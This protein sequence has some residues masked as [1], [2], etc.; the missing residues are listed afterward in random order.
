MSIK[1]QKLD[2]LYRHHHFFLEDDDE[3]YFAGEYTARA[4]FAE[5]STNQ[6]IS[7]LKK[8]I[9]VRGTAQWRYK[10][11]AINSIGNYQNTIFNNVKSTVTFVPVPP[12]RAKSDALYDDRLLQVL[13][14]MAQGDGWD[15]CELVEQINTQDAAHNH[16]DGERPSIESLIENYRLIVP[17]GYE[18]RN[19]IAIYD[20]VL[21]TGRHFK[22]MQYVIK[23]RFPHANIIG[24][25]F[26]RVARPSGIV[27]F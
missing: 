27:E 26:A 9:S 13:N 4:G 1:Y 23:Q 16:K 11:Q 6:L 17:D 21:T 14:V 25:F 8:C 12:S 7:N 22:A 20:D 3:V 18:P 15:V 2:D 19:R 24:I 10:V 5:S